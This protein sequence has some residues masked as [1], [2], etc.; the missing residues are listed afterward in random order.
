L[1][2]RTKESGFDIGESTVKIFFCELDFFFLFAHNKTGLGLPTRS[3]SP[4]PQGGAGFVPAR[5]LSK[6]N[7][8]QDDDSETSTHG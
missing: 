1:W 5:V 7:S 2:S 3:A 8:T 4:S 6:V